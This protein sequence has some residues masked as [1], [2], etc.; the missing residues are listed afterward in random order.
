MEP[1]IAPHAECPPISR[2]SLSTLTRMVIDIA[3][4]F[5]A[6]APTFEL[7]MFS[8]A[9][10]HIVKSA[11]QHIL[12]GGETRTDIWQK[13]FDQLREMLAYLNQRWSLAGKHTYT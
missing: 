11:Q 8:P 1:E 4:A 3:Y 6:A 13:D 9:I 2:A 10:S 7:D 5:N 12:M